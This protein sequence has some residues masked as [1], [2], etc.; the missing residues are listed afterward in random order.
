MNPPT[1]LAKLWKVMR[2]GG[3]PFYGED[4]DL[5][6]TWDLVS[7]T[8]E[9]PGYF[10]TH[11]EVKVCVYRRLNHVSAEGGEYRGIRE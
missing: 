11:F 4:D 8:V 3:N 2:S 5:A 1:I 10:R 6:R 7:E 9:S